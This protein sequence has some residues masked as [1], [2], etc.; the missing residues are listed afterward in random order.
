[1]QANKLLDVYAKADTLSQRLKTKYIQS[2]I[3][4]SKILSQES[5]IVSLSKN[6]DDKSKTYSILKDKLDQKTSDAYQL[7]SDKNT[8]Y[9]NLEQFKYDSH[10]NIVEMQSKFN[11]IMIEKNQNI[12]NWMNKY[13]RLE[14][15]IEKTIMS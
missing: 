7:A 12:D 3:Q 8:L 10:N 14:E 2:D 15:E 5:D 4:T 11:I 13:N 6:L 9:N 1:M